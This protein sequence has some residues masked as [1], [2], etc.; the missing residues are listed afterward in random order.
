MFFNS[1]TNVYKL[2]RWF[3]AKKLTTMLVEC[4][5]MDRLYLLW[6]QLMCVAYANCVHYHGR[7]KSTLEKY[8]VCQNPGRV[9]DRLAGTRTRIP[10]T[11][12]PDLQV[13]MGV[14]NFQTPNPIWDNNSPVKNFWQANKLINQTVQLALIN[15][16]TLHKCKWSRCIDS[17]C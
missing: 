6:S 14:V 7:V 10:G 17:F 2:E 13:A 4:L 16:A 1:V 12:T 8:L 5:D 3:A 11:F 15:F 9:F